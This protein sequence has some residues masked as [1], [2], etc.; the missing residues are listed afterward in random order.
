MFKSCFIHL[1]PFIGYLYFEER[2]LKSG[3]RRV[4]DFSATSQSDIVPEQLFQSSKEHGR[5]LL[6]ERHIGN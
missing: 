5:M 4:N 1:S 2:M 3:M 6:A